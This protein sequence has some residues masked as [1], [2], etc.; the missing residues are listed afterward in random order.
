MKTYN[1]RVNSIN[2]KVQTKRKRLIKIW[3]ASSVACVL[4][5]LAIVCSLPILGEGVP[6]INAYKGDEYYPLIE[7]N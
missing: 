4:L 6:N 3:T 5:V 7:K 1:E 2:G